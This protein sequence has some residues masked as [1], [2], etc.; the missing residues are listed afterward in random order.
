ML[1]DKEYIKTKNVTNAPNSITQSE[2]LTPEVI[3]VE[4]L[5]TDISVLS[6]ATGETRLVLTEETRE[7]VTP[8]KRIPERKKRY[9]DMSPPRTDPIPHQG[10]KIRLKRMNTFHQT[11]LH[12]ILLLHN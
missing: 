12:F 1:F 2:A 8:E 9:L 6:R 11:Y 7:S 4:K 10:K 3:V 5:Q